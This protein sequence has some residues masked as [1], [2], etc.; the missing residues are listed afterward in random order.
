MEE[1]QVTVYN[2][3]IKALH[4]DSFI[5][6][7]LSAKKEKDFSPPAVI[8]IENE[9]Y[10]KNLGDK[11]FEAYV[12][13]TLKATKKGDNKEGLIISVTYLVVYSSDIEINDDVLKPFSQSALVLHTWPYFRNFVHETTMLMG[14]PPLI[15]DAVPIGKNKQKKRIT[16]SDKS[17]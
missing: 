4:L 5:V 10:Y 3:F 7:E 17:I 11:K 2:D 16:K 8:K 14:L 1:L 6:L 9:P 13:Y 12:K 15:L